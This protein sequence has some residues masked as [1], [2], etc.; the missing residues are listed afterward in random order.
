[1]NYSCAILLLGANFIRCNEN[2]L[3]KIVQILSREKRFGTDEIF[4]I[5]FKIKLDKLPNILYN[6]YNERDKEKSQIFT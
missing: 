6:R 3:A 1:M 2:F 5:Y 4:P